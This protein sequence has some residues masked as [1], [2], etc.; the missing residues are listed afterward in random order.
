[1]REVVF[2]L[3]FLLGGINNNVLAKKTE[4][5]FMSLKFNEVNVRAGPSVEFPLILSYK[6][7]L[8]PVKVVAEYDNWYKIIDMDG[9]GGWVR[10]NLLSNYRTIITISDGIIYS[11]PYEEAYPKYKVEKNV[12][13]GLVKC[14]ENRCKV[15]IKL[16]K[17]KDKG[18]LDKKI[19]WGT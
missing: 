17:N 1:M 12:V 9:D 5:S 4:E 11:S 2:V 14:K 7:A 10:K 19:I 13:L 16:G 3:L 6:T 15:V 8:L 18:W